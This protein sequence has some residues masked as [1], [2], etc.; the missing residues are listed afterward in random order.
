M[1][2]TLGSIGAYANSST[3]IEKLRANDN[4][5]RIRPLERRIDELAVKREALNSISG[6]V[7]AAQGSVGA[8]SDNAIY[9]QRQATSSNEE[10]LTVSVENNIPAQTFTLKVEQLAREHMVQSVAYEAR[11]AAVATEDTTLELKANGASTTIDVAEGTTLEQVSNLINEEFG[12]QVS[13]SVINSSAGEFRL[14]LRNNQTG[15]NNFIEMQEAKGLRLRLGSE[16]ERNTLQAPTDA[17]LKYNGLIVTRE[18][19]EVND[20]IEG[21]NINL[22]EEGMSSKVEVTINKESITNEVRGFIDAVNALNAQLD[23]VAGFDEGSQT[24]GPLQ[25]ETGIARLRSDMS[26]ILVSTNAEGESLSEYGITLNQAG[27]L[28]FNEATFQQKLDNDPQ[29]VEEFFVEK[30]VT[31]GGRDQ[32][33]DGVFKQFDKLLNDF[34][35]STGSL[36]TLGQQFDRESRNLV[37]ERQ[38]TINQLDQ[39]YETLANRFSAF[40]DISNKMQNSF[41]AFRSQLG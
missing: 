10:A 9:E 26:S 34:A 18:S 31:I 22:H 28:N 24:A 39:K 2:G 7:G 6:I 1:A 37:T 12:D 32:T 25:N 36:S 4:E 15:Q 29:K 30:R 14:V 13:S 33:Q 16:L 17:V 35:G 19:N 38:D 5:S 20:L 23:G 27:F 8:L 11:D 41:A 40:D 3:V 21:V